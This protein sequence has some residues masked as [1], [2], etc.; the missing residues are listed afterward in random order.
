[1]LQNLE[2]P[3]LFFAHDSS[4]LLLRQFPPCY[5][6]KTSSFSND[7]T[8]Q[9]SGEQKC[10]KNL[11]LSHEVIKHYHHTKKKRMAFASEELALEESEEFPPFLPSWGSA[12]PGNIFRQVV[13]VPADAR[14]RMLWD[15][16]VTSWQ[17][18]LAAVLKEV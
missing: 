8:R 5:C 10:S 14:L 4:F 13:S 1:M 15:I 12:L 2:V 7:T 3:N 16:V 6:D 17:K 9:T 11:I 18:I